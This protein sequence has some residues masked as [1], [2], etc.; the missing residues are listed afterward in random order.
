MLLKSKKIG[1]LGFGNMAQ[2]MARA[3][4]ESGTVSASNIFASN[5]SQGKLL[6]VAELLGV[7]AMNTNEEMIE[8]ADLIIISTK[9]Q[10]LVSAVEPLAR[11]FTDN[12]IVLSMSAGIPLK[13]LKRALPSV[14]KLGRIMP[15]TPIQIRRAV[16]GYCL[17]PEAELYSNL[18]EELL[19]PM[20]LV[21]SVQEGEPFEALTVSCGSGTGFVFE[22]MEYWQEWLEEHGFDSEVARQM[23]VETFLGAALLAS[24]SSGLSIAELQDKVVSRKGV[25]HAGLE[26]MRE[27]EIERA[28]RYSFEKAV[29]R[30]R[31]LARS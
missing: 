1:F 8:S 14:K 27:L 31:E 10:D 4:I 2:A 20:G 15:N 24:G 18:I 17:T 28:L 30:D 6:K 7:N 25:T 3:L 29:L 21:V 11:Y 12:Q 19:N 5:R 23:T 9:P 13:S 16:I 22:L 26:S